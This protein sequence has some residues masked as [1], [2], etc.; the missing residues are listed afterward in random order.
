MS[1]FFKAAGG[2]GFPSPC[3][4][5]A[6]N[7]VDCTAA[8][9]S[10]NVGDRYILDAT[11]GTVHAGWDG[12]SKRDVVTFGGSV[13]TKETPEE[14]WMIYL[15]TPDYYRYFT[16]GEWEIWEDGSVAVAAH[17]V[18]YD[19]TKLHTQGTDTGLDTG[20][21]NPITAATIKGHVDTTGTPHVSATE[22]TYWNAKKNVT[23]FEN[24]TGSTLTNTGGTFEIN[25]VSGSYNVW[26]GG[27]RWNITTQRTVSITNDLTLHYV[28][29]DTDG[30]M[31]VS[32]SIW[33]ILADTAPVAIVYKDGS[34]YAI[35][36]ERH[37][38]DRDRA[39]H[40]AQH[41]TVGCLYQSGLNGTFTNLT[42][43]I[44]QGVVYDED[45]SLDTGGTKTACAHWYRNVGATAMRYVPAQSEPFVRIA[46]AGNI[47]YD[48]AGTLTIVPTTAGGNY[49]MNF[50]YA[51]GDKDYP[52]YMVCGQ[53]VSSVLN[54]IRNS[55]NPTLPGIT[56]AEW[57][58]IYKTIHRNVGGTPTFI[59][60]I[61][62]RTISTG[63]PTAVSPG[64]DHASLINRDAANSHPAS[65][66]SYDNSTSGLTA[67]EAQ[68]AITELVGKASFTVTPVLTV[69]AVANV[70]TLSL[71]T[72]TTFAIETTDAVAK[73]ITITNVPATANRTVQAI[74]KLLNTNAVTITH[75]TGTVWQD[76]ISPSLLAGKT[77][78]LIYT[79]YDAGTTWLASWLGAW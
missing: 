16:V 26:T 27:I 77:Y 51:T 71:A 39:W 19:H 45:L 17:C 49:V 1:E 40:K 15:T 67:T 62:V 20:G 25:V 12:A 60:A 7:Y 13:W 28:Y 61:D 5:Q 43:S 38:Y 52:I 78:F 10:E 22:K 36:D 2:G 79:T 63:V 44:T 32:T 74:V 33:D 21:S 8:P 37:Y 9:P 75:P 41:S 3:R 56:T 18:T 4:K 70:Y 57:K 35:S 14:G 55:P 6:I 42:F 69:A 23:G 68:A 47:A 64:T 48:N 24:R 73:T 34:N 53:S 30:V 46:P 54:T 72:D 31:K 59:E 66:I 76:G 29:F 65:A 50:W 11:S 58:L